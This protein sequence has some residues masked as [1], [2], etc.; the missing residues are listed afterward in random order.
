[1]MTNIAKIIRW[2]G[3]ALLGVTVLIAP[4]CLGSI[5]ASVQQWL[6]PGVMLSLVCALLTL[7]LDGKTRWT[8]PVLLV[9]IL[10]LLLL[11]G[12]QLRPHDQA[13]LA[14]RSPKVAELRELL[15]P[16]PDSAEY[17]FT[18]GIF[19]E[20]RSS[21]D[22]APTSIYPAATRHQLSLF[23]LV[24][25]AFFAAVVVLRYRVPISLSTPSAFVNGFVQA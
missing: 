13:T 1:M 23:V 10:L 21:A 4:W 7:L 3:V 14:R 22:P 25:S 6:F 20:T 16:A 17:R 9:P 11:I 24:I 15:L 18:R 12:L 8:F 5:H 2:I 19:P